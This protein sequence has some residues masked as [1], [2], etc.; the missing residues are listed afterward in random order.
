MSLTLLWKLPRRLI[1]RETDPRVVLC[2]FENIFLQI[3]HSI[4]I[5]VR[6]IPSPKFEFERSC[7][8]RIESSIILILISVCSLGICGKLLSQRRCRPLGMRGLRAIGAETGSAD[9]CLNLF[10]FMLGY[11]IKVST[12][13]WPCVIRVLCVFEGILNKATRIW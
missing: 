4:D 12:Y 2:I 6:S 8:N 3:Y 11:A 13:T 10:S 7:A 5:A 1:K 9:K